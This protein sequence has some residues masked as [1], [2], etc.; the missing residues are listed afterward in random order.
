M[1]RPFRFF[2]GEFTRGVYLKNLLM[3]LNRVAQDIIDEIVYHALAHFMLGDEITAKQMSMREEDIIGI[4]KVAGVFQPIIFDQA[5]IGS[6]VQFSG[7]HAVFGKERSE[8]GLM[9]MDAEIFKY[10]NTARDSY[11]ND[12]ADRASDRL[13]MSVVPEGTVPVGYLPHG[14]DLYTESG[15]VI[16]E[17]LLSAPP[18]D[19]SPYTTFY[20]EKFLTYAEYF[21]RYTF[22]TID[23]F[24]LLFECMQRI[25]Y[26]GPTIKEFLDMTMIL[27]SG[28]VH[29]IEVIPIGVRYTV[30]YRLDGNIALPDRIRRYS[31]WQHICGQKFKLFVLNEVV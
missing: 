12:I 31:A 24:K 27:C 28:Y 2:R 17:N 6:S 7:S 16:W 5:H 9:D 20:G 10:V 15:E 3:F 4:S 18:I 26:S 14:L 8:R 22:L 11:P 25:R 19:G 30:N 1:T 21:K 29:N 13:R 23:I